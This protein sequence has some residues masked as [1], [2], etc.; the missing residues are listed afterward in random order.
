MFS[1]CAEPKDGW[2]NVGASNTKMYPL[3]CGIL[4]CPELATDPRF[5]RGEDRMKRTLRLVSRGVAFV[6]VDDDAALCWDHV[7]GWT[8]LGRDWFASR[9]LRRSEIT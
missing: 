9:A 4:G 2:L 3:L 7:A 1:G 5:K 8:P 6:T